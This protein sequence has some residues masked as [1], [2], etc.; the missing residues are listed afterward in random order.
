[1]DYKKYYNCVEGVDKKWLTQLPLAE[2]N[3]ESPK[4]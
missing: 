2:M 3:Q 1:M 4:S